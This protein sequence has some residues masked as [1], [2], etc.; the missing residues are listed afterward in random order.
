M[1]KILGHKRHK[2]GAVKTVI[3]N[4]K[5][6]SKKEAIR[7][8]QLKLLERAGKI[9]NLELQPKFILQNR[10]IYNGKT[11]RAITYKADF[12]Y[13]MGDDIVIEDTKGFKTEVFNIKAKIFKN[14]YPEYKFIV[15]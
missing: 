2:Y 1:Q 5:F 3:D 9:Y 7:Y 13:K 14:K 12:K 15:N 6:D 10:F 8:S 4:I 11:I